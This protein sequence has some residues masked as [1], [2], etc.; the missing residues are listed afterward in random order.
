MSLEVTIRKSC[1]EL[2]PAGFNIPELAEMMDTRYLG[3]FMIF[4]AAAGLFLESYEAQI[5]DIKAA[6]DDKDP[7]KIHATAHKFKGA[8]SNFHDQSI[9]DA[10]RT[11]EVN[12]ATW[13]QE[14]LVVQF[15]DVLK[16]TTK[17]VPELNQLVVSFSKIET[18][19]A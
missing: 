13:T 6:I 3:E 7:K 4:I 15:A 14:Q 12:S 5:A 11:I 9:A 2:E 10:V 1:P 18:E 16:R 19:A 8:I 17:F